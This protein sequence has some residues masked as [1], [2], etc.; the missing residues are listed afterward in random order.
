MTTVTPRIR[1]RRRATTWGL[2][3]AL[4]AL[5]PVPWLHQMDDD[6]LGLAWRLDGRLVVE[7]ASIDP[8]GRWSWLTV[9]RPPHLLE[10]ASDWLV[11]GGA[12]TGDLRDAPAR[13]RPTVNEPMAAAVGLR[14][15]GHD[16]TLD[17]LVEVSEPTRPQLP[18]LGQVTRVAGID[19]HD[20]GD[21][22]RALDRMDRPVVARTAEGDV[23]LTDG[24]GLPYDRVDVATVAPDLEAAIAGKLVRY[25]P[26]AWFRDLALGRSHGMMVALLTY[27]DASGE[28]LARGRHVAGTGGIDGNGTVTRIGG[29]RAKAGAARDAGADVLLFPASQADRLDGFDAGDMDLWGVRTLEE[30]VEALRH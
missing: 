9:G 11:G 20:P 10:V 24:D 7:G 26:V 21:W 22:A 12:H 18:E 15:A 2:I 4:L 25:A 8:P 27:V 14:T 13:N 28:D 1:R 3:V 5:L 6:P 17:L 23:F 16:V 29:L 30:A 19:L